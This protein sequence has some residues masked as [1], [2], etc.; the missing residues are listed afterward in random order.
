MTASCPRP[1]GSSPTPH[2]CLSPH[3]FSPPAARYGRSARL[4]G[5][6]KEPAPPRTGRSATAE[7]LHP[8]GAGGA[9]G[10][11]AMGAQPSASAATPCADSALAGLIHLFFEGC[12][13]RARHEASPHR[14]MT[15]GRRLLAPTSP[16]SG[17]GRGGRSLPCSRNRAGELPAGQITSRS[18]DRH[19]SLAAY[20]VD[21]GCAPS[22]PQHSDCAGGERLRQVAYPSSARNRRVPERATRCFSQSLPRFERRVVLPARR[23]LDDDS[24]LSS[25]ASR[26]P[27]SRLPNSCAF[28]VDRRECLLPG[29]GPTQAPRAAPACERCV[30]GAASTD[31]WQKFSHDELGLMVRNFANAL[32]CIPRGGANRS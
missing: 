10:R 32:S 13:G 18:Q 17:H 27:A 28:G 20:I 14:Q 11:G 21:N 3:L 12:R 25:P 1:A 24:W 9:G 8:F 19:G 6:T 4:P 15:P 31:Q 2:P 7:R 29:S 22:P 16:A 30:A 23:S 26:S 5:R